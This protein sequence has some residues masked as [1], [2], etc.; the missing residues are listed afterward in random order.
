MTETRARITVT[1]EETRA[2]YYGS[3]VIPKE[4]KRRPQWVVHRKKIPYDPKTGRRASTTDLLTWGTFFE[5]LEALETGSYE[6]VGFVF[7]SADPYTGVDLDKCRDPETGD[8][9]PEAREVVDAFEGAYM[10][11]SPS[12]TGVHI[13]FKG[14]LPPS[15][16][17][18]RGWIE[19]YSQDRYFTITGEG[20]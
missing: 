6:G 5:A 16:K 10:E 20:L 12:G 18:R 14:K 3:E 19:A 17:N 7:C 13:I 4:L 1:R 8:L 2:A 11:I 15:K 9:T